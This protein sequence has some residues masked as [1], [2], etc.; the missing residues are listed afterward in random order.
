MQAPALFAQEFEQGRR[1]GERY[2][3]DQHRIADAGLGHVL[4]PVFLC[5]RRTGFGGRSLGSMAHEHHPVVTEDS[6]VA[7]E[8]AAASVVR[9]AE[10]LG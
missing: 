8:E 9:P 6:A 7:E 10:T 5:A 4:A 2:R 3:D 1:K